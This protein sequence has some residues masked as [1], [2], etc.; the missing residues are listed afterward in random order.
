M[1][2]TR[3]TTKEIT[4]AKKNKVYFFIL[5]FHWNL[6]DF[7]LRCTL[8][9]VVILFNLLFFIFLFDIYLFIYFAFGDLYLSIKVYT[10][11]LMCFNLFPFVLIPAFYSDGSS[12]PGMKSPQWKV[13]VG[14]SGFGSS[15]WSGVAGV[16]RSI[17]KLTQK[18]QWWYQCDRKISELDSMV[19]LVCGKKCT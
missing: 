10:L 6:R 1:V 4:S 19:Y 5:V 8:F 7:Y 12:T 17:P 18:N 9:Y 16:D 2:S 11:A 14:S 15:L 3:I 13:T